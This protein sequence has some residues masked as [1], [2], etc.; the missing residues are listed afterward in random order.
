MLKTGIC[1]IIAVI[2]IFLAVIA[3][4]NRDKGSAPEKTSP[5]VIT[6]PPAVDISALAQQVKELLL[7]ELKLKD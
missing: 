7:P 1:W 2:G 5:A 4:L 3:R 6:I